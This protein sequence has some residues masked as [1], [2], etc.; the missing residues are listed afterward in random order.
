MNEPVFTL[1]SVNSNSNNQSNRNKYDYDHDNL[2]FNMSNNVNLIGKNFLDEG[3]KQQLLNQEIYET[4]N[5]NNSQFN[6]NQ[7]FKNLDFLLSQNSEWKQLPDILKKTFVS[8][9]EILKSQQISLK[10]HEKQISLKASKI[11][12]NSGLSIKANLADL[13]R[14]VDEINTKLEN[15]ANANEISH[16]FDLIEKSLERS[17][18]KLQENIHIN[19]II[20]SVN[21]KVNSKDFQNF[22]SEKNNH[23]EIMSS[24]ISNLSNE[25]NQIK[26]DLESRASVDEVNNALSNKAN[27][28]ALMEGLNKKANIQELELI[29]TDFERV[30]VKIK[31]LEKIYYENK[32]NTDKILNKV[33]E[34]I[35]RQ[36]DEIYNKINPSQIY[37]NINKIIQTKVDYSVIEEF[38]ITLDHIKSQSNQ[39]TFS[40]QKMD[41]KINEIDTDIDRLINNI[42]QDSLEVQKSIGN[43]CDKKDFL[44]EINR[45]NE[46]TD[47][48]LTLLKD[49]KESSQTTLTSHSIKINTLVDHISDYRNV[50][51]EIVSIKDEMNKVKISTKSNYDHTNENEKLV[52]LKKEFYNELH[53]KIEIIKN[54]YNSLKQYFEEENRSMKDLKDKMNKQNFNTSNLI[55]SHIDSNNDSIIQIIEETKNSIYKVIEELVQD[56]ETDKSEH[57]QK[58]SQLE[59]R[60]NS[61]INSL[62]KNEI[63]EEIKNYFNDQLLEQININQNQTKKIL[64]KNLETLDLS[65]NSKFLSIED[66]I[67]K[68]KFNIDQSIKRLEEDIFNSE[69]SLKNKLDSEIFDEF[70]VKTTNL[71][72]ELKEKIKSNDSAEIIKE[73]M[74]E[75][76]NSKADIEDIN[77][78][79]NNI[80]QELD[81]KVSLEEIKNEL[82]SFKNSSN[83]TNLCS[84]VWLWK[85]GILKSGLSICWDYSNTETKFL[86]WKDS[87]I[88][89]NEK[90]YFQIK[91]IFFT[92]SD[93]IKNAVQLLIDG[94]VISEHKLDYSNNIKLKLDSSLNVFYEV[95]E[96]IYLSEEMNKFAVFLLK[97]DK[98]IKCI[99]QVKKLLH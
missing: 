69:K 21:S 86:S 91:L 20:N 40:I 3:K 82:V 76:L 23:M 71:F 54:D 42:K 15:K 18:V 44:I 99:C 10:D 30:N 28:T 27:K 32:E 67:S 34:K 48:N 97:E 1:N 66:M 26:E 55:K 47:V 51:E 84:N 29:N 46:L 92:Y 38:S 65:F 81:G 61:Q 74:K 31:E 49:L 78:A 73:S 53:N 17:E 56:I 25:I 83:S 96:L 37:N 6:N 2:G 24:K 87:L 77:K 45:I 43:K 19:Q 93:K 8:I 95:K 68:N 57:K 60:F 75:E 94:K 9:T 89:I 14:S 85:S 58:M 72:E 16:K 4:I 5:N 70:I 90:G 80:Y 39:N 35:E 62:E 22:I 7:I 63:K 13:I 33:N 88:F 50:K 59:K 41:S 12:I 52:E 64:I 11:E 36:V 98:D 79:L